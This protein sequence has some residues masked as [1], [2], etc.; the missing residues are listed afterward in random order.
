[1]VALRDVVEAL[2]SFGL[3]GYEAGAY[4][5]VLDLGACE[6]NAVAQKADV[7]TGRIYDVLNGLVERRLLVVEGARPKRYRAV[8]PSAALAQLLA[9]RRREFDEQYASLTKRANELERRLEPR[10]RDAAAGTF[11]HVAVG[12]TEARRFMAEKARE[13][14]KELLL[15]LRLERHMEV[16]EEVFAAYAEAAGRGVKIRALVPDADI[17]R[18]LDSEYNDL[19]ARTILPLLGETVDV[20]VVEGEQVPFAVVDREKAFVGVKNPLD[21]HAYFALVFVWDPAFAK[22][23]ADRFEKLWSTAG[24]DVADLAG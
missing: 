14:R 6:A 19:I 11:Y 22:D 8:A 23:L 24:M 5:A 3:S 21:P 7:P 18:I 12:E 20:R 4:A 16:D 17:P 9:V 1:M 10:K 2:K 15:T 13:A